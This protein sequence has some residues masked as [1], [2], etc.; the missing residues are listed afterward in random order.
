[1]RPFLLVGVLAVSSMSARALERECVFKEGAGLPADKSRAEAQTRCRYQYFGA[2]L[3]PVVQADASAF[4]GVVHDWNTGRVGFA[5]GPIASA[6]GG[7][8]YRLVAPV[9]DDPQGNGDF[10]ADVRT[11]TMPNGWT[12]EQFL[13]GNAGVGA[14]LTIA[15]GGLGAA[16]TAQAASGYIVNVAWAN[17]LVYHDMNALSAAGGISHFEIQFSAGLVAAIPFDVAGSSTNRLAAYG[18]VLSLGLSL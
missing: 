17:R 16:A 10:P 18:A 15:G 6:Q 12:S 2:D 4:V 1:M 8:R 3:Q 9:F 7:V 11:L 13:V 14:Q 5:A